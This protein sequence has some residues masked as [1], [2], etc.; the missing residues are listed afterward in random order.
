MVFTVSCPALLPLASYIRKEYVAYTNVDN[1]LRMQIA[2]AL[3]VEGCYQ[4][5]VNGL[6]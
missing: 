2:L 6:R 5:R 1:G 3:I 4:D